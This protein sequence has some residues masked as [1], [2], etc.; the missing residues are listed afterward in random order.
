MKN[1]LFWL[2]A[3]LSVL[4]ISVAAAADVSG[5]WKAEFNTPDGT[6]RVNT[7]NFKVE[8][9]KLTGTELPLDRIDVEEGSLHSQLLEDYRH[10]LWNCQ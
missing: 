8:G 4:L 9:G 2:V 1:R 3:G 6:A 10:W 7:F 5:Q